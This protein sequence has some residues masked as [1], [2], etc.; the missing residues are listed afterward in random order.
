M[1]FSA[2]FCAAGTGLSPTIV[3]LE[4]VRILEPCVYRALYPICEYVLAESYTKSFMSDFQFHMPSLPP[5]NGLATPS[6]VTNHHLGTTGLA[7]LQMKLRA[8]ILF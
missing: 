6:G 5:Q 1:Q 2:R 7:Q 8:P 3:L 4:S